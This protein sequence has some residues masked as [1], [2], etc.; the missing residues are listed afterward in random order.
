MIKESDIFK[1][2]ARTHREQGLNNFAELFENEA[3]VREASEVIE[4]ADN[5]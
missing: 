1:I 5:G 4:E 3:V 2:M